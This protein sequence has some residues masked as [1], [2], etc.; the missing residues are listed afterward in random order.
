M[1]LNA[2]V[3]QQQRLRDQDFGVGE[4]DTL[5]NVGTADAPN[6]AVLI[7]S[8]DI[9]SRQQAAIARVYPHATRTF[10]PR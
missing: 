5:P 6:N 8:V 7:S 3:T 10:P 4:A 1:P 9:L 2:Q